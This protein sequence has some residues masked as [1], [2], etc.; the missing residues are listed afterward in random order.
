MVAT[1]DGHK[2]LVLLTEW[3][4]EMKEGQRKTIEETQNFNGK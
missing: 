3:P 2:H 4:L 1:T